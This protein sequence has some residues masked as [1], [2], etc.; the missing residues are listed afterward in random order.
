V[1][2]HALEFNEIDGLLKQK[3]MRVLVEDA[4][5]R[6]KGGGNF[7]KNLGG[8]YAYEDIVQLI[9]AFLQRGALYFFKVIYSHRRKHL[10]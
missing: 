5:S 4:G 9:I 7:P 2:R 1:T 10:R 6:S 8:S 3:K